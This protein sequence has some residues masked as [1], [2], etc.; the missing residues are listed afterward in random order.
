M[1][2]NIRVGLVLAMI[3]IS[4]WVRP[5][6][7]VTLKDAVFQIEGFICLLSGMLLATTINWEDIF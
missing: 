1:K 3:L 2:Q 7:I 6:E 4:F 5:E